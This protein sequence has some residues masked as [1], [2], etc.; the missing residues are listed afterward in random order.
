MWSEYTNFK[1]TIIVLFNIQKHNNV[2]KKTMLYIG[3]PCSYNYAKLILFIFSD[4]EKQILYDV[5]A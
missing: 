3:L 1:K 4:M 2:K 5:I